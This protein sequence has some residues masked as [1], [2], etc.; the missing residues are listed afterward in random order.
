MASACGDAQSG[1]FGAQCLMMDEAESR[2]RMHYQDQPL[3]ALDKEPMR[4]GFEYNS[5]YDS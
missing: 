3:A 5:R 1:Q 2:V 4:S